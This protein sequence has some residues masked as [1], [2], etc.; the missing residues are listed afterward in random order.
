MSIIV[1]LLDPTLSGKFIMRYLKHSKNIG[2]ET[3]YFVAYEVFNDLTAIISHGVH[4]KPD[5]KLSDKSLDDVLFQNLNTKGEI[6]VKFITWQYKNFY[7]AIYSAKKRDQLRFLLIILS[8]T[9]RVNS[10][11]NKIFNKLK[12]GI[13]TVVII[14]MDAANTTEIKNL[15]GNVQDQINNNLDENEQ[16]VEFPGTAFDAFMFQEVI[17][18]D[19]QNNL[20]KDGQEKIKE[21]MNDMNEKINLLKDDMNEKINLLK[22]G[23]EKIKEDM[24]EKINLLKDD[25]NEKIN[26]LKDDINNNFN[27]LFDALINSNKNKN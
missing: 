17:E 21:D 25:M 18:L 7:N 5:I 14:S 6:E 12:E 3:Q 22:D 24:N 2:I 13:F 16:L 20:L 23:Q 8:P 27:K 19:N 15:W 26:L 9:L 1:K 11:I 4:D 10:S